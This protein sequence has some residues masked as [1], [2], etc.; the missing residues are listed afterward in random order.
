MDTSAKDLMLARQVTEAVHQISREKIASVRILVDD[1][2]VLLEGKVNSETDRKL[3]QACAEQVFGVNR[4]INYLTF[5]YLS[6]R[7]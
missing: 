1:G 7:R 3:V 4:V 2:W 6:R 5:P